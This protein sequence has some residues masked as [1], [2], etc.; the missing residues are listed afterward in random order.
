M[1][2]MIAAVCG[3]LLL[4]YIRSEHEK[5]HFSMDTYEIR[6][7]KI[8]EGERTFVFLS[9]L[10]DNRFG[11]GQ[12]ELLEAIEKIHP[13]GV[14]IGGD[15][16]ITN[17]S[18]N[19]VDTERTLYLVRQLAARYPV[20]YGFGNHESRMQWAKSQFGNVYEEFCRQLRQAGVMIVKGRERYQIDSDIALA[21]L[22]IPK[23]YYRKFAHETMDV[24]VMT[25]QT[26]E[27]DR[28]RYQILLA[29]TPTM[30]AQ[31]RAWGADLTLSGHFHGGT[32]RV[33]FLGGLMTPQFQFFYRYCGGRFVKDGRTLIVSRGMGT[34]SVNIR[35]NNRAQLVVIKLRGEETP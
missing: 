6:S 2:W 19:F 8:R 29:H 5:R 28:E 26:G 12:K 11:A 7:G 34:H 9:D 16:M 24:R 13:D 3:L 20:Y 31:Y 14:L 4:I 25:M 32:I 30:F 35:L 22:E 1:I 18:K 23:E 17:R 33:P 15:M 10:H 27:A 21:G